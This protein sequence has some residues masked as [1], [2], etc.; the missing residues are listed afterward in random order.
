MPEL[1]DDTPIKN[2][3]VRVIGC[4]NPLMGN[5]AVGVR[6]INLLHETHPEIDIIEGG[7]EDW[8]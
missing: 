6:V 5:D 2:G 4:G 8:D 3:R 7:V 1:S